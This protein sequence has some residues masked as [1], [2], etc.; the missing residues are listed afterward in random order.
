MSIRVPPKFEELYLERL[1]QLRYV[2]QY[3]RG[4]PRKMSS[5]F[6]VSQKQNLEMRFVSFALYKS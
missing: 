3:Q 6:A 1:R 4:S 5:H 2:M